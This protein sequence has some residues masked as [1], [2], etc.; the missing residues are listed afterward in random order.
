[1][2]SHNANPDEVILRDH[3]SRFL[4]SRARLKAPLI[5]VLR[6]FGERRLPAVI[7]GGALRDLMVH[8]PKTEPRDV[9]VVVDGASIEDLAKLFHDVVV[10]RTRFGG[11]HLNVRGWMV[12]VWPLSDTWALRELGIGCRDFQ[13]LTFTT[14]LNVEAVVIDLTNRR[15]GRQ[16]YSSGFFE[17]IRTRIL[18]INLEENPFPEL[19]AIRTLVTA[20]TLKYGMSKR[21]ARYVVHHVT[22]APLEYS[23]EVQLSHYG[24]ARLDT[25]TIHAWLK[26]IREQISTQSV[27]RVPL[28]PAQ[29]RL[30]KDQ[31]VLPE[32]A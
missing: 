12:D 9:D 10:R 11:L 20:S 17:A 6:R 18:D 4:N 22:S 3:V 7:F 32:V 13:A 19:S 29:L 30:W 8:G 31:P 16:I 14:F 27:I 23:V 25:D 28:E 2:D 26:I 1:M 5:A 21:L 15:M 24:R